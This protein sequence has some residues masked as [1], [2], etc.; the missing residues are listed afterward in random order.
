MPITEI[1]LWYGVTS[2]WMRN[3]YSAVVSANTSAAPLIL[4][5]ELIMTYEIVKRAHGFLTKLSH[6]AHWCRG[7]K[8]VSSFQSRE[9]PPCKV[10]VNNTRFSTFRRWSSALIDTVLINIQGI[11]WDNLS[12]KTYFSIKFSH[13]W[14]LLRF[15]CVSFVWIQG[16]Q[17]SIILCWLLVPLWFV[18]VLVQN[19]RP[20]SPVQNSMLPA[21][22]MIV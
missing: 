7:R 5:T 18:T 17:I 12:S 3:K 20:I 14:N 19:N 15:T 9:V 21:K 1:N 11:I 4:S 22:L 10:I 2:C 16:L 6:K 13:K 8:I